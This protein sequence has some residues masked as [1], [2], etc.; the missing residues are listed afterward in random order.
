MKYNE[1]LK[2]HRNDLDLKQYELANEFG[3]LPKTY[4]MYET[5][6]RYISLEKLDLIL[7]KFNLSLD[8]VLDINPVKKYDNMKSI[9]LDVFYSNLRKIRKELGYSQEKMAKLIGCNQ[10]TL[11]EYERGNYIMPIETIKLFCIITN[12]SADYLTGRIS[13][14]VLAQRKNVDE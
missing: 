13:T 8:Y 14:N 10:Q 5:G 4:S 6:A 11:S 9:N 7:L 1:I 2:N 3:I 12:C